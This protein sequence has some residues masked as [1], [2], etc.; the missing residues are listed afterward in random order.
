MSSNQELINLEAKF[1]SMKK[2]Y[3]NKIKNMNEQI[4]EQEEINLRQ[5]QRLREI[6]ESTDSK[7]ADDREYHTKTDQLF[8]YTSLWTRV[9]SRSLPITVYDEENQRENVINQGFVIKN[10][11]EVPVLIT[12]QS[13]L[14]MKN[15]KLYYGFR[16]TMELTMLGNTVQSLM[17]T[18]YTDHNIKIK[19]SNLIPSNG[20]YSSISITSTSSENKTSIRL[21]ADCNGVMLVHHKLSNTM[22]QL[23]LDYRFSFPN[24]EYYI[25][26]A[27]YLDQLSSY[28]K[29]GGEILS[30]KIKEFGF[31]SLNEIKRLNDENERLKAEVEHFKRADD[32]QLALMQN[33]RI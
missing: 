29:D 14:N 27:I 23:P 16:N 11:S 10:L 21:L 25:H 24:L 18:F 28:E 17:Y 2:Y 8:D 20:S 7:E 22:H 30:N 19:I 15:I 33:Y 9:Q 4:N 5:K 26:P 32:I 1:N 3:E 13:M 6:M 12:L 31:M